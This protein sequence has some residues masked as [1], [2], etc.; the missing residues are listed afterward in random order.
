MNGKDE[1]NRNW[2]LHQN[3][4]GAKTLGIL[5]GL[6]LD[7]TKPLYTESFSL[8]ANNQIIWNSFFKEQERLFMKMEAESSSLEW[9]DPARQALWDTYN[10]DVNALY[11]DAVLKE[12]TGQA[13]LDQIFS[14]LYEKQFPGRVAEAEKWR[15]AV[16]TQRR[17]MIQAQ[18]LWRTG[19]IPEIL[20]KWGDLLGQDIKDKMFAISGGNAIHTFQRATRDK[21]NPKFYS[22]VYTQLIKDMSYESNRT[23]P[24]MPEID[25]EIPP[26]AA[27]AL[28]AEM[29]PQ[30]QG[31]PVFITQKMR[32][33]LRDLG[34]TT[35]DISK[36]TPSDAWELINNNTKK[37]ETPTEAP[38]PEQVP[39]E[40]TPETEVPPEVTPT[41]GEGDLFGQKPV[42]TEAPKRPTFNDREQEIWKIAAES[43]KE[44]LNPIDSMGRP[45]PEARLNLIKYILKY[46]TAAKKKMTVGNDGKWSLHWKDVTPEDLRQAI[47]MEQQ[48]IDAQPSMFDMGAAAETETPVATPEPAVT[49]EIPIMSDEEIAQVNFIT[50]EPITPAP[51]ITDEQQALIN[52]QRNY[53]QAAAL[54]AKLEENKARLQEALPKIRVGKEAAERS[55]LD[56]LKSIGQEERFQETRL[57]WEGFAN[58][59]ARNNPGKTPADWYETFFVG[60]GDVEDVGLSQMRYNTPLIEKAIDQ[61]GTTYDIQEAGYILPDGTLLDFSGRN[62]ST[63]Y[64]KVGTRYMVENGRDYLSGVRSTDHIEI[65]RVLEDEPSAGLMD[66]YQKIAKFCQETGAVRISNGNLMEVFGR[67]T[68]EQLDIINTY[69]DEFTAIDISDPKTGFIIESINS[70]SKAEFDATIRKINERFPYTSRQQ[71]FGELYQYMQESL[72]HDDVLRSMQTEALADGKNWKV[73]LE[74]TKMRLDNATD[75][76]IYELQDAGYS[77]ELIDKIMS[78][79]DKGD[80]LTQVDMGNGMNKYV[81]FETDSPNDGWSWLRTKAN[82]FIQAKYAHDVNTYMNKKGLTEYSYRDMQAY[83]KE[84][85]DKG[86]VGGRK[87]EF[88]YQEGKLSGV[89]DKINVPEEIHN[90][91]RMLLRSNDKEI[92]FALYDFNTKEEK[93]QLLVALN[94]QDP[95]RAKSIFEQAMQKPDHY[96]W[97]GEEGTPRRGATRWMQDGMAVM[98]LFNNADVS[99]VFHETV[100]VY[101]PQMSDAHAEIIRNY[102]QGL[103]ASDLPQVLRDKFKVADDWKSSLQKGWNKEPLDHALESEILATAFER[104]IAEGKAPTPKLVQVFEKF[105]QWMVEIYKSISGSNIDIKLSDEVRRVF[106]E[107]TSIDKLE[108]LKKAS[109][110]P[111]L[112]WAEYIKLKDTMNEERLYIESGTINGKKVPPEYMEVLKRNYEKHKAI[113]DE[114]DK[115]YMEKNGWVSTRLEAK[116]ETTPVEAPKSIIQKGDTW[117]TVHSYVRTVIDELTKEELKAARTRLQKRTDAYWKKRNEDPNAYAG[118]AGM[119]GQVA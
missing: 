63:G 71:E 31:I 72:F 83:F 97:Q 55:L 4:E 27:A 20:L 90:Y 91:A 54:K 11:L 51:K 103:K 70:S 48:A 1:A 53:D 101:T 84:L 23:A 29:P 3:I 7:R 45:D 99:T 66:P 28:D 65:G 61:F 100:H 6:G 102:I 36:M 111:P 9:G 114:L 24:G 57:A 58:D 39:P 50:D 19:T 33:D 69:F 8:I 113:V 68:R 95:V 34:Y 118:M 89:P 26:E 105:K 106:D 21:L 49:P 108:E 92:L 74:G 13:R 47:A 73:N 37:T 78:D 25:T 52:A 96:L 119:E 82:E 44:E 62:D 64:K 86:Y 81:F 79:L 75:D 56:H 2:T 76:M 5:T 60:R 18:M 107:W 94:K 38:Q 77:G 12:E 80:L 16:G 85:K 59:W 93:L 35:E 110:K 112:D 40:V 117:D 116:P 30:G 87:A 109:T 115:L 22:E 15:N 88:L 17:R 14:D 42:E 98:H 32:S 67:L 43:G 41:A 104:Y 10:Q 46:S